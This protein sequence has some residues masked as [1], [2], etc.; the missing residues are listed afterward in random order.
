[1]YKKK[2]EQYIEA[3]KQEMLDD[4][5]TLC[6]INSERS[7]YQEGDPFGEGPSRA[8]AQALK[9]AEEYGFSI[10]NYD[11]YVGTADLNDGEHQLDILAHLDVVPAGEGWTVTQP[12]EPIVKDGKL[13]GRGTADDK[14]PAVAAL[15]AMRAVKELGIPVTK[16]VRLILGTDEECGSSDIEHYYKVEKEAPMTFSPDASFPVINIEKGR[17]PGHVTASFEVSTENARILSIE[18]GIKINVVPGKAHATI[19]GLTEEEVRPMAEGVTKET[20]V[21]FELQAEEDAIVITAIGEGAHASTP[22]EGKNALASLLLLLDRLPF[23]SCG[24]T[25]LI[26]SLTECFPWNDTEG[27]VDVF[28]AGVGTGGTVTG[29]GKYLKSQN[30]D[31][32]VVAVEPESSPVLS[33]GTAGAHKIQGIGAGFVP[34][35]LDTS[36]YDEVIAVENDDAFETGRLVGHSEGVLVGISSGAA[37]WAAIELAKRPENEGKTIVALLADTGERY[38]ST[39]LFTE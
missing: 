6:S 2:I 19:T 25:K 39:P 5:C 22:E 11:N 26:H 9:M 38:L 15:Y 24:Q 32:K 23:A 4:I 10:N 17:F 16:N 7:A 30:P 28:V 35:T 21:Q 20:G 27:K 18:A 29:V 34:D 36:V 1:M 33:K 31:V 12:F 37:V 3:H 14:G 13:Y 8:L